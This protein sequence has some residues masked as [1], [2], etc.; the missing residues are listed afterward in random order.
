MITI[1]NTQTNSFTNS[2]DGKSFFQNYTVVLVDEKGWEIS[3]GYIVEISNDLTGY[4]MDTFGQKALQDL[5]DKTYNNPVVV[6]PT[7]VTDANQVPLS[8]VLPV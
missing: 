3:V 1:K 8:E 4:E 7:P 6:E 2:E 5:V